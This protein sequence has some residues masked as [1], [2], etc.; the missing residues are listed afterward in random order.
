[1]GWNDREEGQLLET[2]SIYRIRSMT[3]PILGT[4]VLMLVDEGRLSLNDR[5]SDYIP[6]FDR[7]LLK[8]ITVHGLL[9]HTSG[10]RDHG[11]GEIDL[12]RP[13]IKQI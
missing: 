7:D 10:L 9:S 6:S 1:M 13:F 8:D 11:T 5:V 2:G 12:R 4:A 3:K